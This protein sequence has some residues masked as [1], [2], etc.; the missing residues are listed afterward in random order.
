MKKR[1]RKTWRELTAK[2]TT[3]ARDKYRR[4][5]G[6][7]AS[8]YEMTDIATYGIDEDGNVASFRCPL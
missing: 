5:S 3:Q 8:D 6:K 7:L 1:E 2:Q 4:V